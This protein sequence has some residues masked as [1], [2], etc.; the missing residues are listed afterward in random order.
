[1]AAVE[2]GRG[3]SV[4]RGGIPVGNSLLTDTEAGQPRYLLGNNK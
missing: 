4:A 2:G 1:M 3:R